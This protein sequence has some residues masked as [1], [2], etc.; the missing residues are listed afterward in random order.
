MMREKV[1]GRPWTW[2]PFGQ[3]VGTGR[4]GT[5]FF[6]GRFRLEPFFEINPGILCGGIDISWPLIAINRA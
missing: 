6:W 5:S 3:R 2:P 1:L 4:G